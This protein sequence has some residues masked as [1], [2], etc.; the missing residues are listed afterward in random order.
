MPR[1]RPPPACPPCGHP[2]A[3]RYLRD[4]YGGYQCLP[5]GGG[6]VDWAGGAA[7]VP[8]GRWLVRGK[9]L[10]RLTW[11]VLGQVRS[12]AFHNDAFPGGQNRQTFS[13][14]VIP[15]MQVGNYNGSLS[16]IAL[17]LR[18]YSN[19]R[20]MIIHCLAGFGRT[21]FVLFYY[22]MREKLLMKAR[23]ILHEHQI[24]AAGPWAVRFNG[25]TGWNAIAAEIIGAVRGVV[26]AEAVPVGASFVDFC[27]AAASPTTPATAAAGFEKSVLVG[28]IA[29]WMLGKRYLGMIGN[30]GAASGRAAQFN[31]YLRNLMMQGLRR[32]THRIVR[33][34][35]INLGWVGAGAQPMPSVNR[36]GCLDETIYL[37]NDAACRF[38]GWN[39]AALVDEL[40]PSWTALGV[41]WGNKCKLWLQRFNN[42]IIMLARF[43]ITYPVVHGGFGRGRRGGARPWPGDLGED[44]WF[45][46]RAGNWSMFPVPSSGAAQTPAQ[47]AAKRRRDAALA[48]HQRIAPI[49]TRLY[50]LPPSTFFTGGPPPNLI[51]WC[52]DSGGPQGRPGGRGARGTLGLLAGMVVAPGGAQNVLGTF[53]ID[54]T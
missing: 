44:H 30:Y 49:A 35:Q 8:V 51:N 40:F 11:K 4:Y 23:T 34:N 18:P 31:Q 36:F 25:P 52:E 38:D 14:P 20:R 32:P 15:D 16:R 53:G 12:R 46:S 7:A 41:G 33:E 45:G 24:N 29:C 27:G 28:V 13:R 39:V 3:G 9:D 5:H 10:E 42:I 21:G 50:R 48:A 37:N 19:D 54:V 2:A 26:A 22:K 43:F 1:S 6:P 17:G 47:A